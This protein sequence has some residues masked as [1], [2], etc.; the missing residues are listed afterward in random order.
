MLSDIERTE[1]IN[2]L[3]PAQRTFYSV[4]LAVGLVIGMAACIA[5]GI[6]LAVLVA[7][8]ISG[9]GVGIN[10]VVG[11]AVPVII[12]FSLTVG[13]ISN[14][15]KEQIRPGQT[16]EN[17]A[18]QAVRRAFVKAAISGLVFGLLWSLMFEYDVRM[19]FTSRVRM[20]WLVVLVRT[21]MLTIAVAPSVALFKGLLM[22]IEDVILMRLTPAS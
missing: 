9:Q 16:L 13:F 11:V 10:E 5:L 19:F 6:L 8:L 21:L 17:L 2:A 22:V 1:Q 18:W 12:V 15:S 7:V 14:P 4:A 3:S 20:D